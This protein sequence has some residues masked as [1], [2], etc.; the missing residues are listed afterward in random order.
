[1]ENVLDL[2]QQPYDPKRPLIC[3][4]EGLRQL[5]AETRKRMFAKPGRRE[6]YDYEY[7]RN[8]VRNLN[9]FFEPLTGQRAIKITE[10]R[11]R[12]DFAHCMR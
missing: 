8:G 7:K 9:I 6:R 12:Q 2:Y 1:M 4:D 3:F 10:R 5:I 11:T